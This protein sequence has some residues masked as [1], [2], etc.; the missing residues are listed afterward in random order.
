MQITV[1]YNGPHNRS[2]RHN[3]PSFRTS[4]QYIDGRTRIDGDSASFLRALFRDSRAYSGGVVLIYHRGV[5]I[6]PSVE[7]SGNTFVAHV[8]I[9]E[10]DGE[11]TS[12]GNLGHFANRQSAVAFAIRCGAAFVDEAP[13]PKP[14]C[15]K[16]PARAGKTVSLKRTA[17]AT[18][19]V[20]ASDAELSLQA[21]LPS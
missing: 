5:P 20:D 15:G 17:S 3:A 9:I 11:A 12:L 21:Q 8:S 14:P 16:S 1:D 13:M 6:E 7:K 10:E 19:K 18:L 2:N 4:V